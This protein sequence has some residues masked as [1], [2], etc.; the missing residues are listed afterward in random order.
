MSWP[1]CFL[2]PRSEVTLNWKV[3]TDVK[4]DGGLKQK[5]QEKEL[6]EVCEKKEFKGAERSLGFLAKLSC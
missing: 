1:C 5:H 3:K 4:I 2:I 6:S